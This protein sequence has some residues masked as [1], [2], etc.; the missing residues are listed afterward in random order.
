MLDNATCDIKSPNCGPDPGNNDHVKRWEP[1]VAGISVANT[2]LQ[3]DLAPQRNWVVLITCSPEF[4]CVGVVITYPAKALHHE[5]GYSS[6][7]H[8]GITT[9]QHS[10]RRD[11]L[12]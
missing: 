5:E 12:A 6:T 8:E 7:Q 1:D 3:S 9:W 4:A 2:S 11:H 10:D